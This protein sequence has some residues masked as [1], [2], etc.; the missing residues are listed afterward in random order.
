MSRLAARLWRACS[1]L[2][3]RVELGFR[4]VLPS[5]HAVVTVARIPD[6][7]SPNGMLLIRAYDEIRGHVQEL[8]DAGYGLS[9]VDEPPP[10]AGFD[11][12]AFQVMFRDWGWSGQLGAK[13][14]WMR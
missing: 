5:G 4:V 1:A 8:E 6:F 13:P 11:L 2:G 12:T 14:A 10:D 7:G 3:L 9:I